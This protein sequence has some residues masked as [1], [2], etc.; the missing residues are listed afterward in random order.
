VEACIDI[1][2]HVI[3]DRG[4]TAPDNARDAFR[5]LASH[6]LIDHDLA[7]R[8]GR[9]AG[10]RNVLVHDEMT[11]D[12]DKLAAAIGRDLGDLRAFGAAAGRWVEEA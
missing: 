8:L 1:A 9:A 11:V 2:Y 10:L 12:L 3:G 7:T 5:A 4:W 6:G